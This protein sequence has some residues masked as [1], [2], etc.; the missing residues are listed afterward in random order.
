MNQSKEL[1]FSCKHFRELN[2]EEL[3]ASMQLRQEVFV[4]EQDCPY[5]DADGKDQRS[6]HLLA[7]QG[8]ELVAYTRLVPRGVSYPDYVSIG[9]VVTHKSVRGTGLGK[10]LMRESI[11]Q[12]QHLFPD[13]PVKMSAQCYLINFYESFG[14]KTKG[15][16]YLEDGIPHIAMIKG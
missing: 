2:I 13:E 3:Y 8:Q 11:N 1:R 16:E 12:M 6:W 10:A 4:V 9:R 15:A 14:F 5:L 7:W